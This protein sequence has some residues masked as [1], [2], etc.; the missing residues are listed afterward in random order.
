[1]CD[2]CGDD[3]ETLAA[4]LRCCTERFLPDGE[5]VRADGG[6]QELDE[7]A[8]VPEPVAADEEVD[9]EDCA[10]EVCDSAADYRVQ[11]ENDYLFYCCQ[12]CS[13]RNRVY[14]REN[15]LLENKVQ[16]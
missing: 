13:R 2:F 8:I 16:P 7:P 4:A 3:H 5:S 10:Y 6:Q 14:A 9:D 11:L 15:D 12:E 1:M